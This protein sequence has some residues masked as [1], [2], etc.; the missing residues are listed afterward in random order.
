M[1]DE[2]TPAGAPAPAAPA[3][4]P[5]AAPTPPQAPEIDPAKPPPW[6]AGRLEEARRV[7][8][9]ALLKDLGVTDSAKA[10]AAI[11]AAQKA[12]EDAKSVGEKLGET[13]KA[14]ESE[15]KRSERYEVIV[16]D[17]AA[18]EL[19]KLSPEHQAAVKAIAGDEPGAQLSAIGVL[20]PTWGKSA[21]AATPVAPAPPA[22][23][24]APPPV[25]PASGSVSPPDHAAV[26]AELTKA[27]PFA[28]ARYALEH[29]HELYKA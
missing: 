11:A 21:P 14:L 13:A 24:T 15:K 6:L 17:H 7:E 10:K 18:K 16:K 23:G 19:A 26:H 22:S 1:A 29:Q 4:A 8:R 12:D 28:A 20:A 9:E 2:N 27:N 25:A 5:V 3:V